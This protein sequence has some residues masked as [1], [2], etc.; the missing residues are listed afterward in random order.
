[1]DDAG[2]IT[3]VLL[4]E[5]HLWG[6]R[7]V[8]IPVASL[9]RIDAYVSSTI[10]ADGGVG[11]AGAAGLAGYSRVAAWMSTGETDFIPDDARWWGYRSLMAHRS[12]HT[13]FGRRVFGSAAVIG[14]ALVIA[15]CGSSSSGTT[16]SSSA[17][18]TPASSSS[19]AVTISTRNLP[20]L[21]SVLVNAQG[22]ILYMF[23]PDKQLKVTCVGSC[24]AIWPPVTLASGQKAV[25]AGGVKASLLGSDANPGGGQVV[26]YNKWPLYTYVPDTATGDHVGQALNLNGGLWYVLSPS[27]AVIKTKVAG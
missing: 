10:S 1:V 21:G 7:E 26:T 6:R 9:E 2:H 22:R 19:G 11:D 16:T 25:A 3:H 24:A 20:G 14:A 18:S 13:R 27:G 4:Q 15:G 8:A 5:G 12:V 23:A 17:S